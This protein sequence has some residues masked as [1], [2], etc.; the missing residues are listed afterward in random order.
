MMNDEIETPADIP[1]GT[2]ATVSVDWLVLDHNNPRLVS[3][4]KTT[5]VGIIAQLY[6]GESLSELLQSIAANG[7]LNIEPLIVMEQDGGLVVLEGNRRLAVIRLFRDPGLA[8]R[9]F[10]DERVRINVPAISAQ[11]CATLGRVA[12]YRV[13]NRED[14][15]SYLGFK[16][17]NGAAKW[18]SY[19]KAKFAADWY[20][21]GDVSLADIADRIGDKHDTI[22]RMVNAIYVLEQAE[23]TER[24]QIDGRISPRF[25]L[26]P[27]IRPAQKDLCQGPFFGFLTMPS[28]RPGLNLRK[29]RPMEGKIVTRYT[30]RHKITLSIYPTR[31]PLSTTTWNRT[32]SRQ[33][34]WLPISAAAP[35][36]RSVEPQAAAES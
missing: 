30:G 22:K 12:V 7:Y 36:V 15:R 32:G 13:A 4:G 3:F 29:K 9:V 6:R 5:D 18:E 1:L 2:V 26:P 35:G 10:Q 25:F 31:S 17:I 16:H 28:C 19:A 23:E 14:A 8:D 24:F 20:R 21:T 11:H 27:W 33:K 34:I